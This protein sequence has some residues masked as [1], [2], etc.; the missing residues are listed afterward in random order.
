[1]GINKKIVLSVIAVLFVITIL[2]LSFSR[3][4]FPE[5]QFTDLGTLGGEFSYANAINNHGCVVGYSHT[6]DDKV[7]PFYW[8]IEDGMIDIGEFAGEDNC[9]ATTITDSGFVV[10]N[11]GHRNFDL[12]LFIWDSNKK[13]VYDM[14]KE[15]GKNCNIKDINNSCQVVG[16]FEL[17]GN[18]NTS[19]YWDQ[20]NGMINF[21]KTLS[22]PEEGHIHPTVFRINEKGQ[23]IGNWYHGGSMR[24]GFIWDIDN[25][26]KYLHDGNFSVQTINNKGQVTGK[27]PSPSANWFFW[28]NGKVQRIDIELDAFEYPWAQVLKDGRVLV[29]DRTD[30][31]IWTPSSQKRYQTKGLYGLEHND[32]GHGVGLYSTVPRNSEDWRRDYSI[33]LFQ[34]EIGFVHLSQLSISGDPFERILNKLAINNKGQIA[35]NAQINEDITHAFVMTPKLK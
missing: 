19:F 12:R 29:N 33:L 4:S 22:P 25:G 11:A 32:Y 34:P 6:E 13:K 3:K 35:G 9:T 8:S 14:Q 18:V 31:I 27:S 23:A 10:I 2:I 24:H 7:H 30:L 28:D 15:V 5:Y 21:N 1:M 16:S 20:K 17:D 26:V